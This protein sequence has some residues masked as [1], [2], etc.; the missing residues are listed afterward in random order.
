[1]SILLLGS[2]LVPNGFLQ[3]EKQAEDYALCSRPILRLATAHPAQVV[4]II[5]QAGAMCVVPVVPERADVAER[6]GVG[7]AVTSGEKVVAI[8]G[9]P[10]VYIHWN[11][12]S[13]SGSFH[14]KFSVP[15]HPT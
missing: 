15:P 14:G 7:I 9:H 5:W 10:G 1:L 12:W 8:K 6:Y 3:L 11:S 2:I 4:V 13:G